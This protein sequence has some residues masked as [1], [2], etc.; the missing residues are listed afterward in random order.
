[1]L[2]EMSVELAEAGGNACTWPMPGAVVGSRVGGKNPV[3]VGSMFGEMPG[4]P[5]T[6]RLSGR[7]ARSL[8]SLDK[9]TS[10]LTSSISLPWVKSGKISLVWILERDPGST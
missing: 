5:D 9:A 10:D 6:C 7:L 1:M 8:F 3:I 2:P 4:L